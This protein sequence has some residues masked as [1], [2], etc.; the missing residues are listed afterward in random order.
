MIATWPPTSSARPAAAGRAARARSRPRCAPRRGSRRAAA[1]GDRRPAA[2]PA[3]PWPRP[4]SWGRPGPRWRSRT[5]SSAC[6][7]TW[8]CSA[9][10]F[11]GA[12]ARPARARRAGG[13]GRR[14]RR[15][16]VCPSNPI[17]SIGPLLAVPGVR[18]GPGRPARRASWP[19]RPSSPVPRSRARPTGLMAELGTEPSVVGVARLYAPWVGTLVI[20]EA[21]A[22]RAADGRGGGRA[23]RRGPDGHGLARAGRRPG[24]GGDRCRTLR[25]SRIL[26]V[27]GIGEVDAR[28]RPGPRSSPELW[29]RRRRRARPA[30]GRRRR[31]HPEDRVE[32][33]GAA[34]PH[35]PRRPR[36]QAGPGRA[37]VGAHRAPPRRPRH[38]RDPARL[39]LRQRRRRPVQRRPTARRRCCPRT[40]TARPAGSGPACAALLGV[41]VGVIVSD[42]FGRPWR[43]GVTDVAIGC[44]GVA[45]VVDLR[46]TPDAGRPRARGHRGLRGRRAGVGRRA[47]HGQG[48]GHP[49]RHRARRARRRGCARRRCGPRSSGRRP[50]TSSAEPAPL[51]GSG[52][53][54]RRT[55]SSTARV[56][57]A[58]CG[59]GPPP[60]LD[61]RPLDVE[62]RAQQLTR[63]AAGAVTGAVTSTP[64]LLRP[65]WRAAR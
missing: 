63:A 1:A 48:P 7:T 17:V 35:R 59:P 9:V 65:W 26:P 54:G 51:T 53:P 12:D 43:R 16:V 52:Q 2:H 57:S 6:A 39:R 55:N 20:D 41:D 25:A 62:A 21:D 29:R 32:G 5:T 56:P 33:R 14:R 22:A 37:G 50:R 18:A 58:S 45:A 47:R 64:G 23:L 8:R 30:H 3:R 49:R 19:S 15:I 46:G 24:P 34:G 31:R 13:A 11:D 61:G 38:Q 44:A 42:T 10:R 28:G 4:A 60:E 27:T 36:G 40:P